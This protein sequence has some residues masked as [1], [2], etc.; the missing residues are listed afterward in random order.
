MVRKIGPDIRNA[1]WLF[2]NDKLLGTP[3]S[4]KKE[5]E[6]SLLAVSPDELA[7]ILEQSTDIIYTAMEALYR[8][9]QSTSAEPEKPTHYG[10]LFMMKMVPAG[11]GQARGTG[12][13]E[14]AFDRRH[15]QSE[16]N[17]PDDF[18]PEDRPYF[19]AVTA[20]GYSAQLLI[21]LGDWNAVRDGGWLQG[22]RPDQTD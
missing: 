7:D 17:D 8:K 1:N 16:Y 5:T 13:T 6:S 21:N 3:R 11:I 15:S 12:I 22:Q 9:A 19:E 14:L 20:L 10:K 18:T 2:Y 4:I